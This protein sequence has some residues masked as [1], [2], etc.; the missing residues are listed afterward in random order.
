M[1]ASYVFEKSSAEYTDKLFL[2]DTDNL[3]GAV[4]YSD[5]FAA[6]GF[7]IIRYEDDLQFRVEHDEA[8][9]GTGKYAVI[10]ATGS[11]IP[12]DIRKAFRLFDVSLATLFPKLNV[13]AIKEAKRMNYDLLCI[14]YKKNFKEKVGQRL[15]YQTKNS[16]GHQVQKNNN[17]NK[18][19]NT[20]LSLFCYEM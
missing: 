13:T 11:Y 6:H 1:F 17:Y 5:Y 8:I 10:A 2:I 9:Y 3:N 18:R 4:C 12:Y 16:I 15:L 19:D 14:A 7:Q 20:K